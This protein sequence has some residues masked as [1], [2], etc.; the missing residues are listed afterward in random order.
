MKA[1]CEGYLHRPAEA[2]APSP[3]FVN[4]ID[5]PG[6]QRD[7]PAARNPGR[8]STSARTSGV[9]GRESAVARQNRG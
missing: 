2:T 1:D 7:V 4:E 3:M 8:G 5:P 9:E 6:R